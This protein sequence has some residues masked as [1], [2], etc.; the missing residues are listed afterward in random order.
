[1]STENNTQNKRLALFSVLIILAGIISAYLGFLIKEQDNWL[2]L[3]GP[4]ALILCFDFVFIFYFGEKDKN[5]LITNS[6]LLVCSLLPCVAFFV[7]VLDIT[8]LVSSVLFV[9]VIIV[10]AE[11]DF[12]SSMILLLSLAGF[13]ALFNPDQFMIQLPILLTLIPACMFVSRSEDSKAVLPSL[14]ITVMFYVI[15]TVVTAGFDLNEAFT[16]I[17]WLM[18]VIII[19]AVIGAFFL[20]FHALEELEAACS[21]LAAASRHMTRKEAQD[22]K[23]ENVNLTSR[24]G[25]VI[26]Q[27]E[28]IAKEYEDLKKQA[29]EVIPANPVLTKVSLSHINSRQ[30]AFTKDLENNNPKLYRHSMEVARIS[31]EASELIGCD[32][33]LAHA[34]GLCHEANRLLGDDYM[35][36]LTEKYCI[37]AYVSRIVELTR[38]KA[39]TK[40]IPREAGIVLMTDDIINM[41][42]YLKSSKKEIPMERIVTNTIKVRKDQNVLRLAGFSN[43]EIQL[44]KL[45]LIDAGGKYVPSD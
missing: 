19:G 13:L 37:P 11:C 38:N 21:A 5:R 20:H 44:L 29:S 24:I 2:T 23:N 14:L 40:P 22:L 18:A 8:E 39:N 32:P 15:I 10:C 3:I 35:K 4:A 26:E 30:F 34:I 41:V 9:A 1:M 6:V 28:K 31:S 42:N 43:E 45:Y 27:N 25:K 33:E 16:P 36:L 7:S 17:F 12:Y